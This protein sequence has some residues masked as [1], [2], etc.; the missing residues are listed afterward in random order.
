MEPRFTIL[1]PVIRLPAMLPF[2]IETVLEQDLRDFELFV[3]GDGAPAE[4]IAC[5]R[6]YAERDARV[7]VFAFPKGAGCGEAHRH[8]ALEHARG[9][10]VAHI[11]DDDIWFP[12]HLTE[13]DRLLQ[14]VDFG[15]LI[16]VEPKPDGEYEV[17]PSNI[18]RT[19]FRQ[20]ILD[21]VFNTLGDAVTGYR[22]TAYRALPEGW[23][24]PPEMAYPDLKMWRKF[25]RHKGLTFGTRMVVTALIFA[26]EKR[27]HMTL[28]ERAHE[29]SGWTKRIRDPNERAEITQAAWHSLVNDLL[30]RQ[31][32][33]E[34]RLAVIQVLQEQIQHLKT[35][36]VPRVTVEGTI[37]FSLKGNS[38]AFIVS[39]WGG[40][41][42]DMRWTDG[43]AATL[44]VM[45]G[46]PAEPGLGDVR[47]IH[48][49]ARGFGKPQRVTM[50]V[51]GNRTSEVIVGCDWGNYEIAVAPGNFRVGAENEVTLLTPDAYTP[52]STGDSDDQRM[53]G[54]AVMSIAFRPAADRRWPWTWAKW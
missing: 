15:H 42:R 54:I 50:L 29:I 13:L 49:R 24:P 52:A 48:L 46:P 33:R 3:I 35:L 41:E 40:Q 31:W 11:G 20:K 53:L 39:G 27:R 1:L 34:A 16:H 23:A 32:D 5:A 7:K 44:R 28:E 21:E 25:F 45:L 26:T 14:E 43:H 19:E 12:N 30:N 37:D 38:E 47:L 6:G 9:R 17:L 2:A 36:L 10:Y 51:N 18:A 22:M 8:T 4:T